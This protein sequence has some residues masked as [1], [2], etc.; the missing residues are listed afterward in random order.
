MRGFLSSFYALT[1]THQTAFVSNVHHASV[2]RNGDK[3]IISS[4]ER[5]MLMGR[6]LLIL[7]LDCVPPELLFDRFRPDLPVVGELIKGGIHG[8]L[9][10][11][12]PPITSP[13]WTC[14]TS[15]RSPGELG[16]YGFRHRKVGSYTDRYFAFA[17]RIITPRLWETLSKR[18]FSVGTLGVPQTFPV[19]AVNGFMIASF[20]T[21][22][23]GSAFTHPGSLKEEIDRVSRF[24]GRYSTDERGYIIDV[25]EFRTDDKK[26]IL[27]DVYEMTE[28]R[29]V[30]LRHLLTTREPEFLMAVFMGPDRLHHSFWKFFDPTHRRYVPG[31]PYENVLRDYYRYLDEEIGRTLALLPDDTGV[32]VASDH[33]AKRLDGAIAIN[34]WLIKEGYLT[35]KKA[36]TEPTP[37][38]E[39][40]IDWERTRA[41]GWGGYYG[42]I[43]LNVAGREPQGTISPR[44]VKAVRDE[45]I[46]R[47]SHITD[48]NGREIGTVVHRP[49]DLYPVVRGDPPDLFVYFG[50][51][52]W[53]S[54]SLVGRGMVHLAENDTGPDDANHARHGVFI[55][56]NLKGG[57]RGRIDGLQI[58]QV[59][60]TVLSLFGVAP[61][62]DLHVQSILE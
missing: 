50:D 43:F 15:G 48:E 46:E 33:G 52:Y 32:I 26:R 28:K 25:E 18:G 36:P 16:V 60:P 9:R 4:A 21:P 7:G 37:L 10:S 31:N 49:E 23:K 12:D 56:Y 39:E 55:G 20:L 6:R 13:A 11:I 29:F 44:E 57:L 41:W 8:K 3:R 38:T 14:M 27:H 59:A 1:I 34:E 42:R 40:M 35:L 62:P 30:V 58:Q 54:A 61:P 19:K 2:E 45:L 17:D 22:S 51:L 24:S 47:L 53:R 5:G